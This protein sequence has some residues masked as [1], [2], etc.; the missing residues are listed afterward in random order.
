MKKE[1]KE[2]KSATVAILGR[3]N[4]GKSTLLNALM[5]VEVSATSN[6]PQT[7]RTNIKGILQIHD[8][9]K[10]WTGQL[11]LVD[12][13]GVNFQKGLLERSMHMSVESALED[14]DIAIW[15]ADAR[16]F[17]SDLRDL[18]QGKLGEDKV[19]GWLR[20]ALNASSAHEGKTRWILVLSKIDMISKP[21]L[22][23]LMERAAHLLPEFIH[24]VPTAAPKGLK[25]KDSNLSGLMGVLRDMAVEGAPALYPEETWTDLNERQLVQNLVREA[26]FRQ[27]RAEVPYQTDCSIIQFLAP[28]GTKK[29]PEADAV[30]WV[31]RK[32]LKPILVGERGTRIRDIGT[33]ARQRYQEVTG[34]DLILRLFVKVVEKWETRPSLLQELGYT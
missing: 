8:A 27:S 11:V 3:P 4:A 28:E 24:I 33:Y 2:F 19:V 31:S 14:V 17:E 32:S 21:E 12:T 1:D 5:E 13:P 9:K 34:E 29:R 7:T 16:T 20:A 22:L 10:H 25:E 15:V 30:I 26:I 18:E 6:R 23:P